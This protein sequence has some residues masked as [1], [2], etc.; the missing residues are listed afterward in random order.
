MTDFTSFEIPSFLPT[1]LASIG[2]SSPTPV[3][4]QT[5]PIALEGKDI[6][7]SA[8]TG[9]GKTIAYLIPLI[10]NL[11]NNPNAK[12]VILAPTRELATQ[13]KEAALQLL[14]GTKRINIALLIGGDRIFKQ[15][16]ELKRLPRLIIG[17][18]GRINDHL[19]RGS[20]KLHETNF[21]VL[22]ETDR[23]LDMGFS[24]QLDDIKAFM[25]NKHQ[26]LMFSATLP[27]NI[28]NLSKKYLIDPT[29][30]AVG[31]ENTPSPKV[32]QD[33][34]HT[35][36]NDKFTHLLTALSERVGSVIIFVKTKRGADN[37]AKMLKDELHKANAIHGDLPQSK[38]EKVIW[39]FRNGKYR[40]LVATDVAAR[41]LDVPH[42]EHV[43]NFDLPMQAED[44]IHRIGRTG[45]AG[46]E[47]QALSF[48]SPD[49]QRKWRMINQL[50]NP[51]EKGSGPR[52]FS[53]RSS[54]QNSR[55]SSGSSFGRSNNR[56]SRGDSAGYGRSDSGYKGSN[57]SNKRSFGF[58]KKDRYKDKNN[59]LN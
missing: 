11:E 9:T 5:I 26:T 24:E 8:Q 20:L 53:V 34:I 36:E 16:D 32:K 57:S 6:L 46:A 56:Q 25:P 7:A 47:G 54:G 19:N 33:I 42:I 38:R 13:I 17:T 2:I 35:S 3:Q 43:I 52:E 49:D 4:S 23:M 40:I 15:L 30:I 21:L 41:G 45:R 44:Y 29:R 10:T 22:D 14:K 28:L 37:L 51:S 27:S 50:I 31:P 59:D 18:P 55:R 1:S 48:I 58:D 39:A 12:G